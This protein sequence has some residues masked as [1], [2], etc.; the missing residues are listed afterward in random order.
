MALID[1]SEIVSDPDFAQPFVI[2]RSNGSWQ[3]GGWQDTIT[4]VN[5]YGAQQPATAQDLKEI[6]EGDRILGSVK[7]WS[8]QPMYVTRR[9]TGPND[10]GL[11][12][13]IVW[14]GEDYRIAGILPWNENGYYKA[15]AVRMKGD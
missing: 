6:P 2:K 8:T 9:G 12:D 4:T 15:I 14:Q 1:V 5:S 7:V 13:I 3:L 11:S 10:G